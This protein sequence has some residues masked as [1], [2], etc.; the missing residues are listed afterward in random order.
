MIE[1]VTMS[2]N[3]VGRH[4]VRITVEQVR[5]LRNR[6]ASW[7]EIAKALGIGTATAMRLFRSSDVARPNIQDERPKTH[8]PIESFL[9]SLAQS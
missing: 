4:R 5:E 7:R 6:N 3:S 2:A 1:R 8:E 9:R